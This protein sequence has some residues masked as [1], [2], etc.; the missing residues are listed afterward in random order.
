VEYV[1]SSVTRVLS[2]GTASLAVAL[3]I[4][5]GAYLAPG[6]EFTSSITSAV[7]NA[8][9]ELSGLSADR[10][11]TPLVTGVSADVSNTLISF[12]ANSLSATVN[13]GQFD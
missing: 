1:P 9:S 12:T 11:A 7:V 2:A 4:A 5:S 6:S 10:A 13:D 8:P 3:P